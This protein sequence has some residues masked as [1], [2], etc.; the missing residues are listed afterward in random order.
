MP[1]PRLFQ[2]N[3][4]P[5]GVPK[6]AVPTARISRN[7]VEGDRQ[8]HLEFHGGPRRALCL[9]SLERILALQ[10]EGHP[11][12]PG[13]AGENLTLSGLD[14]DRMVPGAKLR[15]GD[16]VVVEVLSYTEPC[17]AIKPFF[18]EGKIGR[19]LQDRNPGWSRVY[20]QV[21]EVGQVAA[22]DLI[23]LL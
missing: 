15:L 18:K 10:E 16:Q 3:V 12:F 4:S 13:A 7:G 8:K 2:I 14:W 11:I 20:A 1:T 23:V 6:L 19:M 17:A 5:G 22:G 21:L 9:Y